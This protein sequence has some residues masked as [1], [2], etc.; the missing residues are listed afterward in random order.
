[1]NTVG[2]FVAIGVAIWLAVGTVVGV[3]VGRMIA[4][5]ALD[6]ADLYQEEDDA[7]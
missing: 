3:I 5:G 2:G 4:L 7:A 6:T 1:M